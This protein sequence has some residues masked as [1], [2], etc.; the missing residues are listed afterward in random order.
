MTS[1]GS[2]SREGSFAPT[3]EVTAFDLPVIGRIPSELNGRYMRNGAN[4]MLGSEDSTN[5]WFLVSGMVHG[6]RLRDGRAACY[7]DRWV[8]SKAVAEALGK[9]WPKD[10]IHDQDFAANTQILAH[11]GRI[12]ATV[13]GGALLYEISDELNTIGLAISPGPCPPVLPHTPSSTRGKA[14]FT[15]SRIRIA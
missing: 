4:F 3:E 14:S 10:P 9:K 2:W 7:R 13:E 11:A 15:P 8:R 6:L 12:L 5:H 1:N